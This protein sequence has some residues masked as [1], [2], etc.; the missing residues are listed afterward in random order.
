DADLIDYPGMYVKSNAS[1]TGLKADFAPYALEEKQGG[2]G[3]LNMMVTK[4][5][6]YIARVEGTRSL[7]WRVVIISDNDADLLN[8]DMVQ[9]LASP[10]Q[11]NDLSWI[12]PGKVAWDWWNDWN[13]SHVDFKS[14][15]NT[16]TYK[17]Y[18]DFAAANKLEYIIL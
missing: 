6:D 9:K 11:L 16:Q 15:V 3:K 8:N 13:I 1:G 4:R 7:P 18:I 14:G 12:K 2:F 10:P 5:A 17:Y